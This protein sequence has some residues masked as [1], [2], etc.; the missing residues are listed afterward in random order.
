VELSW[1]RPVDWDGKP[2]ELSVRTSCHGGDVREA[3]LEHP[4]GQ[5]A[6]SRN[7][8]LLVH[9]F[10]VS[11]CSAGNSY[12]AFLQEMPFRWKARSIWVYWPGDGLSEAGGLWSRARSAASYPFQ[13]D[14]AEK[15]GRMLAGHVSTAALRR[16]K[17]GRPPMCLSVVAHSLGCRVALELVSHIQNLVA[18]RLIRLQ[19]VVLMAAAVPKYLLLSGQRY[20]IARLGAHR[21]LVYF[22]DEDD[23]LKYVFRAG[24]FASATNPLNLLFGRGALG[25]EGLGSL[26]SDNVHDKRTYHGHG[27]YW[28]DREIAWQVTAE[29][30][31]VR[32]VRSRRMVVPRRLDGHRETSGRSV[33]PR[34]LAPPNGIRDGCC[35]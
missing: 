16:L 21:T 7:V 5:L 18:E 26:R 32:A 35:R 8:I 29:L 22:S 30:D 23:V 25:R 24:Q 33:R 27:G 12:E 17:A 2:R 14:R 9:G 20:D 34:R 3:P 4:E 31:G 11:L 1:I 6:R 13:S 15:A 10:N 19:L 28:P